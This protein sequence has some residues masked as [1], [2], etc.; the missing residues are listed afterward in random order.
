MVRFPHRCRACG[1]TQDWDAGFCHPVACSLHMTVLCILEIFNV[2][3][4]AE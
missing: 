2:V 1:Q 3:A 4:N